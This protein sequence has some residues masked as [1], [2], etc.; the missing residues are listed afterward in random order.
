MFKVKLQFS[1]CLILSPQY[2]TITL[3]DFRG[4]LSYFVY[5]LELTIVVFG[6]SPIVE[7]ARWG[8][9]IF[10]VIDPPSELIHRDLT[11]LNFL[12]SN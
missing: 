10:Y 3:R 12:N 1:L 7:N 8:I 11:L 9:I 6:K 2:R 4:T 5:L